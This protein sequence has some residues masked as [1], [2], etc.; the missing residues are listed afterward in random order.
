[1][2]DLHVKLIDNLHLITP[3]LQYVLYTHYIPAQKKYIKGKIEK[4]KNIFFY[5]DY[6][7]LHLH[8]L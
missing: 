1:M 3:C 4:Y 5:Y 7:L 6:M 2:I 8:F